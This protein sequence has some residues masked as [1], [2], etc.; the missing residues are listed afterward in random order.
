MNNLL[1]LRQSSGLAHMGAGQLTMI[2]IGLGLLPQ[3]LY[4]YSVKQFTCPCV[5]CTEQ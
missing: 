3:T 2:L 5:A 1:N 4:P